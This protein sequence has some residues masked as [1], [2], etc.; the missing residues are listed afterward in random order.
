MEP[1]FEAPFLGFTATAEIWN[2]RV[3]MIGLVG[4]FVIELVSFIYLYWCVWVGVNNIPD[5]KLY[6]IIFLANFGGLMV[7]DIPQRHTTDD[8]G[9]CGERT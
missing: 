9:R 6:V 4:I 5:G 3:C 2:S 8:W 1:K 7:A